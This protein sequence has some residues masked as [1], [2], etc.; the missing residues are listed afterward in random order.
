MKLRNLFLLISTLLLLS[1][2]VTLT[3][4]KYK[5]YHGNDY[6]VFMLPHNESYLITVY[7]PDESRQCYRMVSD[8]ELINY[9]FIYQLSDNAKK[10]VNNRVSYKVKSNS[11]VFLHRYVGYATITSSFLAENKHIYDVE[12]PN[13][14]AGETLDLVT[15]KKAKE[16]FITKIKEGDKDNVFLECKKN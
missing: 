8:E 5:E 16:Y 2:C 6:A 3:H 11:V 10:A 12:N 15:N 13:L 1:S 4:S 9:F 7:E 14:L